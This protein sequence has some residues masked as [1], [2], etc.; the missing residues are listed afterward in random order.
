MFEQQTELSGRT[1]KW[2]AMGIDEHIELVTLRERVA[3]LEPLLRE[4]TALRAELR[5]LRDDLE[6]HLMAC[7][8]SLLAVQAGITEPERLPALDLLPPA[9][10]PWRR[11]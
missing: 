5:D 9:L 7:P 1:E 6:H 2:G 11:G 4:V 3:T 8:G 10:L